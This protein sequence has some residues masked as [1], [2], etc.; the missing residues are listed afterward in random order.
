MKS[1]ELQILTTGQDSHWL[2]QMVSWEPRVM[3]E[4]PNTAANQ[5]AMRPK[6]RLLW[7]MQV[8]TSELL[9]LVDQSQALMQE[10]SERYLV[11]VYPETLL[12]YYLREMRVQ[13]WLEVEMN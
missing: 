5:N 9:G 2:T 8:A 7:H 1:E 3:E 11:L 6:E 4:V 10:S 12:R 13:T